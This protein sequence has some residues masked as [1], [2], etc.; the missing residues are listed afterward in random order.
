M[1]YQ[2]IL[3][4]M[5]LPVAPQ[6]IEVKIKSKSETVTLIDGAEMDIL[7][8]PGLSEISFTAEL[9]AFAGRSYAVYENGFQRPG[10]YLQELERLATAKEAVSLVIVRLLPDGSSL[11]NTKT[12]VSLGDYTVTD[13]AG[14]G[15]DTSVKLNFRQYEQKAVYTASLEATPDGGVQVEATKKRP[16]ALGAP[17]LAAGIVAVSAGGTLWEIAKKYLGDGSRW[18]ELAER[19]GLSENVVTEDRNIVVR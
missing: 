17:V 8:A 3:N 13:D 16:V 1:A 5:L 6:K 11:H 4:G 9:P 15:F 2:V 7:K 12:L 14:D 19:N 18:K 10:Y